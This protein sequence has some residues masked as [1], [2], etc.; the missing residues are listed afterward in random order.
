MTRLRLA[1]LC[2][3]GR[4]EL[5]GRPRLA[6]GVRISVSPGARVVLE[7]GCRLGEGCRIEARGGT[8]R[9]GPEATVGERAVLVALAGIDVGGGA[10]VGDWAAIADAGPTYD[11]PEQPTR[12]QPL[13]ATPIAVG[14]GARIGPH[15]VVEATVP[16]RAVVAAHEVVGRRDGAARV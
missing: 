14:D 1:W 16:P 2:A 4:V 12:L 10:V 9:I 8:V 11:D 6:R 13:R 7:D 5:R 3:R 15:A